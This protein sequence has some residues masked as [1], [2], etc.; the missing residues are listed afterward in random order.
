MTMIRTTDISATKPRILIVGPQPYN[1]SIQ[2][3]T[4]DA[5]FRCFEH[6]QLAQIFS[7][8]NVPQ[9]GHCSKLFQ[10]T[11]R[12]LLL[13]RISRRNKVG[14]LFA[15]GELPDESVSEMKRGLIRPTRSKGGIYRFARK[16]IWNKKYWDTE[17]LEAFVKSFQP[18]L[19]FLS[20]SLD[21]F[22]FDIA[23]HFAKEYKIPIVA[24]IVDDYFFI[25][26]R[27]IFL[28]F[29]HRMFKKKFLS[30]MQQQLFFVFESESARKAYREVFK[31]PSEVIYLAS[32]TNPKRCISYID[33]RQNFAYF[34]NLTFDRGSSLIKFAKVMEKAGLKNELHVYARGSFKRSNKIPQNLKFKGFV[35]YEKTIELMKQYS[36][37]VFVEGFSKD[38]IDRIRFSL[39]SKVSDYLS[40]GKPVIAFGPEEAGSIRFFKETN[41]AITAQSSE[42]LI[43]ILSNIDGT[44]EEQKIIFKNAF[45]V[46]RRCFNVNE[47]SEKFK[48][49]VC[50]L[51]RN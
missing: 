27:R 21:T 25:K 9:K 18:N 14:R 1:K 45:D 3:R 19:I 34:G 30:L 4:L 38:V 47:Q 50:E 26:P 28:K 5:Y 31:V 11:D 32:C 36:A 17:E 35:P 44:Q 8:A 10:I 39:S 22:V 51:I 23:I 16:W 6:E 37:L 43:K 48:K 13:R 41:S 29:Y 46:S 15:R 24:S 49:I 7:D 2:S 33:A 40:S 20:T 42:E 12:S